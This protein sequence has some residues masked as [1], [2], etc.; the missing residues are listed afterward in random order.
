MNRECVDYLG[1]S[2]HVLQQMY[3]SVARDQ[4]GRG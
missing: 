2:C 1:K 4:A 3:K